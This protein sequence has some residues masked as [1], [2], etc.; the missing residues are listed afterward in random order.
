MP[1]LAMLYECRKV[2]L[3]P[4]AESDQHQKLITSRGSPL[5]RVKFGDIH[6]RVRELSCGQTDTQTNRHTA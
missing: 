3:E 6:H 4:H 5:V 1:H 2:I